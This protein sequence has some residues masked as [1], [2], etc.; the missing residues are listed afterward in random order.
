MKARQN[1]SNLHL[2][3]LFS[4]STATISNIVTTFTHVLHYILFHDI[5]T[6]NLCPLGLRMTPV[7]HLHFHSLVP[8]E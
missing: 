5:M 6:T 8:V 4:C 1:Y 7:L 2:A 3:Q